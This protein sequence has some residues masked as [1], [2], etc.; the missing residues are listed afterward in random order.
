ML[1]RITLA[2]LSPDRHLKH[3]LLHCHVKDIPARISSYTTALI[4]VFLLSSY[5]ESVNMSRGTVNRLKPPA[6]G[7]EMLSSP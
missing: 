4:V 1:E 6:K 3:L 2:A 7:H 5:E